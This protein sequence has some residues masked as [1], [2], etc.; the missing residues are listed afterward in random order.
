MANQFGEYNQIDVLYDTA[1]LTYEDVVPG[2]KQINGIDLILK[3]VVGQGTSLVSAIEFLFGV[4]P[5][6]MRYVVK[7]TTGTFSIGTGSEISRS[8]T[9]IATKSSSFNGLVEYQFFKNDQGVY[10]NA[11]G[12]GDPFSIFFMYRNTDLA[13]THAPASTEFKT[14]FN[15]SAE[16]DGLRIGTVLMDPQGS[17]S[18]P[19]TIGVTDKYTSTGASVPA[20]GRVAVG[21]GDVHAVAVVYNPTKEGDFMKGSVTIPFS[22]DRSTTI[23]SQI[24]IPFVTDSDTYSSVELWIDG[25]YQ[26]ELLGPTFSNIKP[27]FNLGVQGAP[28]ALITPFSGDIGH[29]AVFTKVLNK[30]QISSTSAFFKLPQSGG[31]LAYD[32]G[33]DNGVLV[34][35]PRWVPAQYNIK[36]GRL[37]VALSQK[38]DFEF[39]VF[40]STKIIGDRLDLPFYVA[41]PEITYIPVLTKYYSDGVWYPD[42]FPNLRSE[43]MV[44]EFNV[45]K[46]ISSTDEDDDKTLLMFRTYTSSVFDFILLEFDVYGGSFGGSISDAISLRFDVYKQNSVVV[47]DFFYPVSHGAYSFQGDYITNETG[48]QA[49]QLPY[50]YQGYYVDAGSRKSA[51]FW[52]ASKIRD[53]M[54]DSEIIEMYLQTNVYWDRQSGGT[55]IIGSHDEGGVL[56]SADV[57]RKWANIN[58]KSPD[59]LRRTWN[60]QYKSDV[61]IDLIGTG[62]PMDLIEGT[63]RG[64]IIGPAPSDN[65]RFVGFISGTG[66]DYYQERVDPPVLIATHNISYVE[67]PNYDE[68]QRI[69]L[70]YEN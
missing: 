60:V 63:A 19:F 54:A 68:L 10:E 1:A 43:P 46:F 41:R 55:L 31:R 23:S 34:R 32:D 7:P 2:G 6:A 13:Q 57:P 40:F 61:L 69:I 29:V 37:N 59:R 27:F 51:I 42:I 17:S 12:P 36:Y 33:Y 21:D 64:I 3:F 39:N 49:D 18:G 4:S 25:L 52:E 5:N 9:K 50:V 62:I 66:F 8:T 30:D 65:P 44:F 45:Q 70:F 16:T 14:I 26:G 28:T 58:G 20:R 38:I 56:T 11:P 48:P 24:A 35:S 15:W 67:T 47:T 22:T 53:R